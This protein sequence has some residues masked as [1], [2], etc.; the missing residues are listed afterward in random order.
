M[1]SEGRSVQVVLSARQIAIRVILGGTII[2]AVTAVIASV[3]ANASIADDLPRVKLPAE[4]QLSLPSGE[5]RAYS[6]GSSPTDA[7]VVGGSGGG[8]RVNVTDCALT[9]PDGAVELREA[10]NTSTYTMGD[11]TGVGQ[12]EFEAA[13][14]GSYRLSC[15]GSSA[16]L[17]LLRTKPSIA[18]V[19]L[20][21]STTS[22]AAGLIVG[23]A[24]AW[25]RRRTAPPKPDGPR[26]LLRSFV[27]ESA[28]IRAVDREKAMTRAMVRTIVVIGIVALLTAVTAVAT[29]VIITDLGEVTST[30]QLAL[31]AGA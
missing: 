13:R 3:P 14:S 10:F 27:A 8:G 21:G 16:T 18:T 6:E 29:V 9:G 20:V 28:A 23:V 31:V 19:M 24:V 4:A 26:E 17:A 12:F 2:V 30:R 7:T 22:L 11:I 1:G 5:Y 15:D 25:W